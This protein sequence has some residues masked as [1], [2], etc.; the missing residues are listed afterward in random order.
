M[1]NNFGRPGDVEMQADILRAALGLVH[2]VEEGGALV[3]YP[4]DW[5]EDFE[6]RPGGNRVEA[7]SAG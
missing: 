7:A 1:G 5:G 3:D 6:F 4:S 2:S